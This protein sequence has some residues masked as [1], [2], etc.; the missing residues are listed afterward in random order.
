[1]S[2]DEKAMPEDGAGGGGKGRGSGWGGRGNYGKLRCRW[3]IYS[4][5]CLIGTNMRS[6]SHACHKQVTRLPLKKGKLCLFRLPSR[7]RKAVKERLPLY[8]SIH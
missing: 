3:S 4:A 6:L 7:P 1:M 5:L 8:R 2:L